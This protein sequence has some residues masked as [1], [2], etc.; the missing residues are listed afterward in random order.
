MHARDPTFCPRKGHNRRSINIDCSKSDRLSWS[1]L[2]T[3][4][5]TIRESEERCDLNDRHSQCREEEVACTC[6]G[7]RNQTCYSLHQEVL[8]DKEQ[9]VHTESQDGC[10]Q[11]KTSREFCVH[12]FLQVPDDGERTLVLVCLSPLQA[13]RAL[14]SSYVK[15]NFYATTG[16]GKWVFSPLMSGNLLP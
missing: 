11:K 15:E 10:V 14:L 8:K 2:N 12:R 4:K 13:G 3:R 5:S 16:T 9:G 7:T 1:T 6:V